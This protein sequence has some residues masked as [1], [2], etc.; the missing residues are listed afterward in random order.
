MQF[1]RFFFSTLGGTV[2]AAIVGII[3][4]YMGM[5][6]WALVAQQIINIAVDTFVLWITVRWRPKKMFSFDRLRELFSYG[7]KLL[8]SSLLNTVYNN[9]R[10]LIIGKLY[11]SSDLA[12]FNRAKQFPNLI[13]TNVNTSIDSVLLP[14]MSKEQDDN[15]RV[16]N[17]TRRAITV[18][19]YIISPMMIGLSV[20]ASPLVSLILTDK[21]L[22]CVPFMR[23]VCITCLFYPIHT[24]NLNAIKAMGRSD[25]Y[26][27]LEIVK[28]FVGTILLITTMWYGVYAMACSL[29]AESVI[30]QII[31]AWPNRKLLNYGYLEQLKDILPNIM[32][33]VFMGVC[34]YPM[35]FLHFTLF[36]TLCIQV[37]GGAVVYIA[38]SIL[39]QM[40]AFQYLYSIVYPVIHKIV[41]KRT[42]KG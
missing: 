32:L 41:K 28:K 25:L 17:M 27:F 14:V 16:K 10:Q 33:S 34:I 21:W 7:W 29:L 22:D 11:S 23:I 3:M 26:L 20:C 35:S 9:V 5:G 4:A 1:K 19:T 2:G 12:F 30:A 38:G 24:A 15:V 36:L 37:S 13:I 39:F 42:M 40:E 6:I 31:N 8:I 18:S